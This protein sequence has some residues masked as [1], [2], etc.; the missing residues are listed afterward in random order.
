MRK[1]TQWEHMIEDE[2][3]R[4][5]L[6][7]GRYASN[8][9]LFEVTRRAKITADEIAKLKNDN[10]AL[11]LLLFTRYRDV[12]IE[13]FIERCVTTPRIRADGTGEISLHDLETNEQEAI[14][15]IIMTPW[16]A[17]AAAEPTPTPEEEGQAQASAFPALVSDES[18]ADCRP[19]E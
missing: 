3:G 12:V 1:A 6:L 19:M 7:K 9:D 10:V 5:Y 17:M 14:L 2:D 8:L 16:N 15:G 11:S 13:V 18:A 4:A